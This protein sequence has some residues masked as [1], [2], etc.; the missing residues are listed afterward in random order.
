MKRIIALS[1]FAAMLLAG[2]GKTENGSSSSES[3][4]AATEPASSVTATAAE[5]ETATTA[6]ETPT[7]ETNAAK[8]E[9]ETTTHD[10]N[11]PAG[12]RMDMYSA[13]FQGEIRRVFDETAEQSG[14]MASIEYA[15]R[16]LDADGIP[17]LILKYGTCEADY[18]IHVYRFDEQCELKDLGLIGGGHTSFGYDE[19]TG[20]FVIVWGHMGAACIEYYKWAN[21]NLEANGDYSF[22]IDESTPSYDD[23]LN[24]KGIRRMEFVS[25]YRSG[26]DDSVKS[27]FYHADGSSQEFEGLYLD[28]MG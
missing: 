20:D 7:A 19:N 17:E 16:D 18:Q 11:V 2:C 12:G 22:N 15:F 24:E 26:F 25:A 23:V 14:G 6:A 5:T 21:G 27:W 1:C 28:Y 8:T 13:V 9:A 10:A 3:T 4:T